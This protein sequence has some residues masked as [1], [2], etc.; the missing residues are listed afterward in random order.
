MLAEAEAIQPREY[1]RDIHSLGQLPVRIISAG[2]A[3]NSPFLPAHARPALQSA[4]N[5]LQRQFLQLSSN[6]RQ[7]FAL[8]S[9]H[10]VQRDAPEVIVAT[11]EELL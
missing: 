8:H 1:V 5:A 6:S 9:G 3:I 11:I 4:W 10:F 2:T 7:S